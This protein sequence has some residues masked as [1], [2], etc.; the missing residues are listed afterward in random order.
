[1]YQQLSSQKTIGPVRLEQLPSGNYLIHL[2]NEAEAQP[3][4]TQLAYQV[5]DVIRKRSR[6]SN[7]AAPES[8]L[9][10]IY[11]S[12]LHVETLLEQP[13]GE[14]ETPDVL[15]QETYAQALELIQAIHEISAK[16]ECTPQ[17]A[18]WAIRVIQFGWMAPYQAPY[19][20]IKDG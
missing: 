10:V 19:P 4:L 12:E 5:A 14:A 15:A 6:S 1:M 17:Q 8:R 20:G 18:A 3:D 9:G 2:V 13:S 7:E 11:A 16:T